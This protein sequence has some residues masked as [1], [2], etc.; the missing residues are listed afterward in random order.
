MKAVRLL[1]ILLAS[2]ALP[3]QNMIEYLTPGGGSRGTTVEVNIHG[4]QLKDP[5]EV[6]FYRPGIKAVNF[7]PKSPEDVKVRFEIA[8]DC[9][10]GEHALRLRT[11]TALSEVVTLWVSPFP[12]VTETEKKIGENDS[13]EQ[14]QLVPLNSTVEGQILPGDAVDK[15]YYRIE[16]KQGQR[17]S[18]EVEGVRLGTL[19]TG[20]DNDVSVRILDAD[21]KE[22]GK[23]VRSAMYVEDPL[24][25]ITAP[26][27]GSY[28]VEIMQ[29]LYAPPRAAYYRAHIGTFSRPTGIYPVGGQAGSKITA[30]ILGDPLGERNEQIT[31]PREPGDFNYFTSQDPPPSPNVLRVSPY[32]NVLKVD[33]DGPTPVPSLPAALNGILSR[34]GDAHTFR[35]PAK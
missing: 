28:F 3:E 1:A 22:L 24:L 34:A 19:H 11:A 21:G 7:Q 15:D 9:P 35:F 6:L 12:Q 27:T 10:L 31:L 17:I 26:R 5:R 16:V 18:V 2:T 30:S 32:A 23:S 20:G 29:Q 4:L 8:P 13:P 25:S 14:A 33:G